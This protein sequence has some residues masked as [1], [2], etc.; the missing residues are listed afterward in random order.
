MMPCTVLLSI[1]IMK[2]HQ[3]TPD[4]LTD[5]GIPA[6]LLCGATKDHS[7]NIWENVRVQSSEIEVLNPW[8]L[9]SDHLAPAGKRSGMLVHAVLMACKMQQ[10]C[11]A[12]T[13]LKPA[14]QISAV[15]DAA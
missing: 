7:I 11:K 5:S 12:M 14:M 6:I 13:R 8:S 10:H 2:N 1:A 9:Y 15:S 4:L 3:W